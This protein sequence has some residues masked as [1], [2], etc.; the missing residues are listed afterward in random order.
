MAREADV[1]RLKSRRRRRPQWPV[2]AP[3]ERLEIRTL[4]SPLVSFSLLFDSLRSTHRSLT[5]SS[6]AFD[7]HLN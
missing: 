7:F 4:C 3:P 6:L 5:V 2:E 1:G